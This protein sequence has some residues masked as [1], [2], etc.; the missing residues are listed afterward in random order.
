MG[1]MQQQ[2]GLR[3][4]GVIALCL[5]VWSI[6]SSQNA[7]SAK[8]IISEG[9]N[10]EGI[11]GS[12]CDNTKA[13]FDLIAQNA[14]AEETIIVIGKLGR[15]ELSR[16]IVRR[17]MRNLQDYIYFTRGVAKE[18]VVMAEGDRINGLGQV[19]VYI[20]GKL[21]VIFRLKRNRDFLTNCEP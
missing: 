2:S 19:D 20:K 17:R 21:V 15:G 18:R 1:L 9:S 4:F 6:A 12:N 13:L 7:Q 11:D 14:G 16:E 5:V 8:P 3:A 10:G